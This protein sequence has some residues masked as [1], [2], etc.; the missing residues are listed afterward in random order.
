MKPIEYKMLCCL[1]MAGDDGSG[2]AKAERERRNHSSCSWERIQGNHLSN[3][4]FLFV[5]R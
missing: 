1:V 3:Q 5:S 2:H 4:H